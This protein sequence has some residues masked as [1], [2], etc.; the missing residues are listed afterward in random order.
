MND[1]QDLTTLS[2]RMAIFATIAIVFFFI[3]KGKK[4]EK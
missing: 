4:V 2:I 3:L 1:T